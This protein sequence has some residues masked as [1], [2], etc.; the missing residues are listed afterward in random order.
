MEK[1]DAPFWYRRGNLNFFGRTEKDRTTM[2]IDNIL[3]WTYR[4]IIAIAILLG[5]INSFH[6]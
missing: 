5:A 3:Y 1:K 6:K 4:I 2:R